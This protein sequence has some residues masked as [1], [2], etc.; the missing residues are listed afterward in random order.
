MNDELEYRGTVLTKP[1]AQDQSVLAHK[2]PENA[3]P[4]F[5]TK[6]TK[7]KTSS[8]L[9]GGLDSSL[10]GQAFEKSL[11][12]TYAELVQKAKME[13]AKMSPTNG[14]HPVSLR[15]DTSPISVL[16]DSPKSHLAFAVKSGFDSPPIAIASGNSPLPPRSF[17]GRGTGPIGRVS[18]THI[19]S[20][21]FVLPRGAVSNTDKDESNNI[22]EE[23]KA[24]DEGDFSSTDVQ[25]KA[26][27]NH[28]EKLKYR[29]LTYEE[30]MRMGI[31]ANKEM[32]EDQELEEELDREQE[33]DKADYQKELERQQLELL[34]RH[35]LIPEEKSNELDMELPFEKASIPED[36]VTKKVNSTDGSHNRRRHRRERPRREKHEKNNIKGGDRYLTH[37]DSRRHRSHRRRRRK[38]V[39]D[40]YE[41]REDLS[42]NATDDYDGNESIT[43]N[44]TMQTIAR[45]SVPETVTNIPAFNLELQK[46][47]EF[48]EKG[49]KLLYDS[50]D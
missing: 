44:I 7:K 45:A 35:G 9:P 14:V 36:S 27:I 10:G 34:A 32:D 26:P 1:K 18:K 47:K 37:G 49:K 38:H 19:A 25:Y 48:E 20:R 5:M 17:A 12:H 42:T 23:R 31:D 33:Q 43:S 22:L 3:I 46:A 4:Y 15:R 13:A 29:N 8:V 30:K 28:M 24:I 2:V 40:L 6:K 50:N 21:S 11:E 16:S 39:E 41:Q